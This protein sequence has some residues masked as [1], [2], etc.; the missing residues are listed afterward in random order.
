MDLYSSPQCIRHDRRRLPVFANIN[1][2]S[3]DQALRRSPFSMVVVAT[4]I[5]R[6]WRCAWGSEGHLGGVT[7]SF[8]EGLA[9][10]RLR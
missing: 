1:Q 4:F 7:P 9:R 8:S 5:S 6:W 10:P 2:E 3:K